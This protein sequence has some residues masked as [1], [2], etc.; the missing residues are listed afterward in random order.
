M[1]RKDISFA[2]K[3]VALRDDVHSLGALVGEVLRDQGGDELFAEVERDRQLAIRR[4]DGDFEAGIEL[5]ARCEAREPEQAEDLVR[6]FTTWFQMVNMAEKVHRVRRRRDYLNDSSRPQPGGLTECFQRLKT[7]GYTLGQ[8]LELL[9]RLRIE[10]VFTAHPT[11]STRRTLLRQQ[12]RI[13]QLLISRLD[14]SLT[15]SERRTALDTVRTEL[16]TG[17]QTAENSREKLT[18]ADEREHVLFFLVEVVYEII[19]LFYEEIEES[20]AVVY[21][22]EAHRVEVPEVL[23][24]G[25]W[26]GGDMDGLPDVH[27]KT[28][29]ESCARH[30]AL[31]VNRYFLEAQDLAEKLSQSG[32]RTPGIPPAVQE[33]IE[34]YKS[35]VPA[36]RASTP[37]G[38]DEMPYRVL[39]GQIAER[40]RA[41]YDHRS[42]QYERE[43]QLAD[44]LQLILASLEANRGRWAG[45]QMVR[46]FL[47]RVR[48]FGLHLAT[49]DV[50]QS[51]EVHRQIVGRA[52]GEPDWMSW[53]ADRRTERLRDALARDESPPETME[54]AG[55]RALWVFEAMKYCRHRY[56]TRAVGSYVVSLAHDIDDI[57]SVLLLARWAGFA[58]GGGDSLPLDVAPLFESVATL[59]AA[60]EIIGRLL[61]DPIYRTHVARRG[62]CQVVMIGYS[63]SNKDSGIAASRWL[64]RKAQVAMLAACAK[65]GVEL[66]VFHGRGG[67]VSRGGS[68]TEAVVSSLPEAVRYGRLRVTEQGETINDRYGLRPIALRTFERGLNT[69][70]LACAGDRRETL[71]PG[72]TE[73]VECLAQASRA[74]YREFVHEDP[75][76]F[77]F[78]Q[79]VTPVD[80]IERMQIGS[81]PVVRGGGTG[82][83]AIR[84]VPWSF[85]WSQSRHMLPGWFGAGT[86]LAAMLERHGQAVADDMYGGWPFF[87][88]LIDDV[89][90]RL[91]RADLHI[92]EHYERLHAGDW[93]HYSRLIRAEFD[94]TR[95]LVLKLKGCR[96]L[97]DSEPTLQRSIWLRNPYVDPIHL[98][99]VDLLRRWREA[100]SPSDKHLDPDDS[101]RRLFPALV[102]SVNGIAHGLQGTG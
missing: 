83:D 28:I 45:A 40:L 79:A 77:E 7:L 31:I 54:A 2:A 33:R 95:E 58:E 66:L 74:R 90:M 91:A 10:P 53:D 68:R 48:T 69:L 93:Q 96:R 22:A 65:A 19:P 71:Q 16:T 89:E 78:F 14:P 59:D 27:A 49:L 99:Q 63:D 87:A 26:V 67:S 50:R 86:G 18:V 52:L 35:V 38:H 39:L 11:E 34:H 30:H 42:G 23:G 82:V 8:T 100:G 12:Q 15:P 56:G 70:A 37:S 84:A 3:D 64:L 92:A 32:R 41:T 61:A 57:L 101:L 29:R 76:F 51:A 62:N 9:G 17:W 73:A 88:G 55:K 25:S 13:A 94:L 5:V 85:A 72:W 6:A 98:I 43:E 46:R 81:R 36:A 21:G 20:L 4:R 75:R 60:G 97:L 44:D 24:F 102:A 1:P 47:R 80:V